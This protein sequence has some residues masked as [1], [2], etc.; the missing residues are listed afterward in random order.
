MLR[1]FGETTGSFCDGIRRRSFLQAGVLGLGGLALSDLFR[2]RAEGALRGNPGTNVILFWLSGGPGHMETWDPKPDAVAQYRGP[3]GAISTAV[4]GV[5]FG[6]LLPE[7]ARVMDKLA[8]LRTVNHGSGDHTKGNHW[9]LTGF[10]G[11]DF[12]APDNTIQRRPALGAVSALFRGANR[13][14]MPAYVGV[15]H[16]R[17]GTDNL[18]HYAAYLGGGYNPFIVNSDPNENNYRVRDLSLS[19]DLTQ[20]R[21]E[22]RQHLLDSID[23]LRARGDRPMADASAHQQRA[24]DLLT[25]REV[26]DAFDISHEPAAL[27]DVYGRHTFGQ[28]ALL[29]RRLVENG[30]TFVTVNCVPW[31]HHGTAGRLRTEEGARQLIPPLDKAIAALVRDLVDRGL[32]DK[33]LVVAMGEFGRTPRMNADGG[34]DHWGNTFSVLMAGGGMRPG[35]VVGKS[36]P[37]GEYVAERP[38]DPQDVAATVYHHLGIDARD[39]TVPDRTGRPMYLLEK[40]EP[41]RELVGA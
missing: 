30:V 26:R 38:L 24:F 2:I 14:G 17:G 8:I 3:F 22:S 16:L 11:P 15:P 33:T 10:A 36:S 9:M 37:R 5:Q 27:R 39:I 20:G 31:D 40:G 12:N 32:F 19:T 6:E 35:Q 4:P 29:A 25:S 13:P 23:Q 21:L 7:Q 34:R 18:F 1:I 41:I 28:S